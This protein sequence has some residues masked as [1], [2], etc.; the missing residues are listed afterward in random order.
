MWVNSLWLLSL[1]ISLTCALLATL[2][3]QWARRYLNIT[4][5]RSC[6][7]SRA[8]IRVFFAEGV[9]RFFLPR[10]IEALPALL[11]ISLFL[12]FAGLT[13]FL[14]NVNLT[15]FK[16]VLSWVGLCTAL[17]GCFTLIPI[18]RHDSPYFTPLSSSVWF[19]V[20]GIRHVISQV[21]SW[22]HP[23]DPPPPASQGV[24]S[25]L[26]HFFLQGMQKI[27]EETALN[28]LPKIN[29][30]VIMWTLNN[31]YKD[32]EMERFISGLLCLRSSNVVD[33]PVCDLD[34]KQRQELDNRS[35]GMLNST[36][37]SGL[38][39]ARVKK[40][41]AM[42]CAKATDPARNPLAF[43][44]L[45][46]IVSNCGENNTLATEILQVVRGWGDNGDEKTR[47]VAQ[48]TR[49][50]IVARAQEH[51]NSWFIL[52]SNELGIP[53]SVLRDYDA[54]S[55]S[56][57]ILIHITCQQ[58]TYFGNGPW[59]CNFAKVLEAASRLN[60]Q[61]TSPELRGKFC[62]LW[63]QIVRKVRN[64][65]D[66]SKTWSIL[67]QIRNVFF[68]LHQDTDSAPTRFSVSTSNSDDILR[69]P[70]SYPL[71]DVPAHCP[72]WIPHIHDVSA[73]TSFTRAV[74]Q[75][76][77]NAAVA[78]SFPARSSDKTSATESRRIL[79]ASPIP[80]TTRAIQGS[81]DTSPR[82]THLST[83]EPSASIT[84]FES[85]AA[86][87]PL[88]AIAVE[89]TSAS[90]TPSDGVDVLSS[91]SPTPVVNDILLPGLIYLH[92]LPFLDLTTASSS[93]GS[94]KQMPVPTARNTPRPRLS[95]AP[96]PGAAAEGEAS[97]KA[98][99]PK[100]QGTLYSSSAIH[101]DVMATPEFPPR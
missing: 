20:I 96:G 58:F 24:P 83:P 72:N 8:R 4:Q 69:Q 88:D 38:L 80:V 70:S 90:Y 63:N 1:V 5:P 16:V 74:P 41:R 15:T 33:D 30:R 99:F 23:P 28:T 13:V 14:W 87:S 100:A 65:N 35:I 36:F 93:P 53:E 85:N 40:R 32:D 44:V 95:S 77:D 60:A 84:P 61:H 81:V 50:S 56:L 79:S 48:A 11:H 62:A 18:L 67:R 46:K 3:Q 22:F 92:T 59:Q 54:D 51:D 68:V 47:L 37:S 39:P 21:H 64:D 10:I 98:T 89:Y 6:P 78:P 101:E 71:C 82:T 43:D 94:H 7:H 76:H 9:E 31:L 49:S 25:S 66:K 52:A 57:A 34:E 17:Y 2:L 97:A 86:A 55:L 12:F 75:D 45:D 73:S 19:I 29:T 26:Y 42:L 91:P 27:A